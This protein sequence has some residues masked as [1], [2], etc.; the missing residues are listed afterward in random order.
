[1]K[2]VKETRGEGVRDGGCDKLEL[3][4]VKRGEKGEGEGE[5]GLTKLIPDF[6]FIRTRHCRLSN[7]DARGKMSGA[8]IVRI[9][10]LNIRISKTN[11]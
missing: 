7:G 11:H 1:M 3:R 8:K 4:E 9:E 6:P 10:S 5:A 2:E